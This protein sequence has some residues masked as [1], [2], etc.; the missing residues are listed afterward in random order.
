MKKQPL[1]EG[2]IIEISLPSGKRLL[3]WVVYVS[4]YFKDAVGL[5]VYPRSQSLN[6][7]SGASPLTGVIYTGAP[8]VKAVGWRVVDN[9]PVDERARH[10]TMRRVAGEV[11]EGDECLRSAGSLDWEQ[12]PNMLAMGIKAVQNELE[13]L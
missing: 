6:D 9:R 12:L 2:D 13:S 5:L 4:T 8:A 3:G 10:R 7:I 1:A 11:W